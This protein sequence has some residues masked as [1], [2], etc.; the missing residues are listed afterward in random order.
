MLSMAAPC[1]INYFNDCVFLFAPQM[2][3]FPT[4]FLN[5]MLIKIS[6][7]FVTPV[8]WRREGHGKSKFHYR[9]RQDRWNIFFSHKSKYALGF[10]KPHHIWSCWSWLLGYGLWFLL[11]CL[12]TNYRMEVLFNYIPQQ[13]MAEMPLSTREA[14]GDEV[15]S[16]TS[17]CK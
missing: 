12:S 2:S 13:P 1:S 15:N 6:V 14:E 11:A 7:A 10:R 3:A 17:P 5:T 8:P 16:P 4:L 9:P